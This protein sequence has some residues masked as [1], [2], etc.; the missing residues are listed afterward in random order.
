MNG[1][2][3]LD[4]ADSGYNSLQGVV[5]NLNEP[6]VDLYVWITNDP[7]GYNGIAQIAGACDNFNYWKSSLSKGPR[8]G[9]VETAE[10]I[11]HQK[12]F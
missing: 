11:Q 8:R 7:T 4:E 12:F 3:R 5:R 9:V 6:D 1:F 10:V 2:L